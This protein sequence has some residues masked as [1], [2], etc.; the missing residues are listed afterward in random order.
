MGK[1]KKP[2]KMSVI[3]GLIVVFVILVVVLVY[4]KE[5][6]EKIF[7]IKHD[8]HSDSQSNTPAPTN[9]SST[10]SGSTAS[11]SG[12]TT[13]VAPE[14][15]A[16]PVITPFSSYVGQDIPFYDIGYYVFNA[17]DPLL[18]NCKQKCNERDDCVLFATR[19][20]GKNCWLKGGLYKPGYI[21]SFKDPVEKKNK[22]NLKNVDIPDI[23]NIK[24]LQETINN[25]DYTTCKNKCAEKDTCNFIGYNTATSTCQLKNSVANP[26]AVMSI[27]NGT[28]DVT[29][30]K[31]AKFGNKEYTR[32]YSTP[33]ITNVTEKQCADQCSA[34]DNC[35]FYS[36]IYD[37]TTTIDKNKCLFHKQPASTSKQIDKI[38]IGNNQYMSLPS[39]LQSISFGIDYPS[40]SAT[41]VDDCTNKCN[42]DPNCEYVSFNPDLTVDKRCYL[43][44]L[45]DKLN[46]IVAFKK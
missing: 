18:E 23:N 30:G 46:T 1:S 27:K 39:A 16:P 35:T 7:G 17:D 20:N 12:S 9:T 42:L 32:W 29:G 3:I 41:T 4:N 44:K 21:T 6:G 45:P 22:Y 25:I 19:N 11:S 13:S 33:E 24:Y 8:S 31:F 43:N 15:D 2:M 34:S 14:D 37:N 36:Y 10:S 40:T 38:K 5:I 28:R 26:A